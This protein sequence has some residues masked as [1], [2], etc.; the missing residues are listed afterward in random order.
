MTS[1]LK[2]CPDCGQPVRVFPSDDFTECD[3]KLCGESFRVVRDGDDIK[4]L[5]LY[6]KKRPDNETRLDMFAQGLL[7]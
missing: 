5:H 3:N 7:T 2:R 4:L 6:Y 1:T